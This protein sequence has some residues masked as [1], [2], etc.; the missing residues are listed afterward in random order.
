MAERIEASCQDVVRERLS[1]GAKGSPLVAALLQNL[2]ELRWP[3]SI[4]EVDDTLLEGLSWNEVHVRNARTGRGLSVF[5][6]VPER[7]VI[8]RRILDGDCSLLTLEV[9]PAELE[10]AMNGLIDGAVVVSLGLVRAMAASDEPTGQLT[11]REREVLGLLQQ[12]LSNREIADRLVI[13]ANTVRTHLQSI[14][15]QLG[16]STRG[17]LAAKARELRLT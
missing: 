14:S 2:I 16:V 4:V 12:G 9:S 1:L 8:Q 11:Q 17:K 5:V 10:A 15:S 7:S 6:G 13:S 3:E